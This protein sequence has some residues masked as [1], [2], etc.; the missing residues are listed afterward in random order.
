MFIFPPEYIVT[1]LTRF[2]SYAIFDLAAKHHLIAP[3]EIKHY[4]FQD[5]LICFQIHFVKI[6]FFFSRYLN[7][8]VAFD[9]IY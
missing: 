4:T 1:E 5:G 9:V 6:Y 2:I 8:Y 7:P 3:H